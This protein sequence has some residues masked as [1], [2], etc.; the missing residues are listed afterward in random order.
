MI[1]EEY[2][3]VKQKLSVHNCTYGIALI[4]LSIDL[5]AESSH[6][7]GEVGE[8]NYFELS[9]FALPTFF[10]NEARGEVVNKK[11]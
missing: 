1:L 4:L 5:L 7:L 10:V 2:A 6:L 11:C 9:Q 3:V 8:G